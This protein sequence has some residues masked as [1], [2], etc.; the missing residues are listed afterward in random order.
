M[1]K[2]AADA[3]SEL[4]KTDAQAKRLGLTFQKFDQLKK[5]FEQ[6]GMA[7]G[8]IADGINTAAQAIDKMKLDRVELL[9]KI[10]SDKAK[11]PGGTSESDFTRSLD[12]LKRMAAGVGPAAEAAREAVQKLRQSLGEVPAA[13]AKLP[14]ME[15]LFRRLGVAMGDTATMIEQAKA[16]LA[17]MPDSFQRTADAIT[18]LG[19]KL[20]VEFVQALQAATGAIDPHV[21]AAVKL[22]QQWN[23]MW[24][25]WERLKT[26]LGE[27]IL[28]NVPTNLQSTLEA[29]D[30]LLKADNW[31]KW[32]KEVVAAFD[33]VALAIG[34]TVMGALNALFGKIQEIG[35]AIRGIAKGGGEPGSVTPAP[36]NASGGYISGPGTATSDSILARLS[37]GE[38]VVSARAVRHWG[39]GF[40][41]ALNSL[42]TPKF[43]M[44]GFAGMSAPRLP[45][46][47]DGGT[48]GHLGTVDLRT[49]HGSVS[50]MASSSA[51]SQLQR[52][53]VTKR[54]TATGRKPGFIG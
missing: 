39:V 35:K 34:D 40:M 5:G 23:R 16:K 7:A 22:E 10:A 49:D 13:A 1:V 53:A 3:A 24:N 14:E 42:Q 46:F 52:L 50:V 20:G 28:V 19:P 30:A 4:Q 25:S 44:G 47:A 33:A 54:I 15:Q 38:F 29:I 48:V 17:T 11:Q 37:N 51:A 36:G 9:F 32:A 45:R 12:M 8:S 27:T 31:S 2:L 43:A 6:T 18:L 41:S 21:A 26:T